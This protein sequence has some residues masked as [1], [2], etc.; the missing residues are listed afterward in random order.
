MG[1]EET[2]LPYFQSLKALFHLIKGF[3][4]LKSRTNLVHLKKRCCEL[5]VNFMD[6]LFRWLLAICRFL[7]LFLHIISNW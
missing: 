6:H 3:D 5:V 7:R 2:R 4:V 1:R